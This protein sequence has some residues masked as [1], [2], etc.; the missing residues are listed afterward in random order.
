METEYEEVLNLDK[1]IQDKIVAEQ[2]RQAEIA[3]KAAEEKKKK[4]AAERNVSR[5][6]ADLQR[7]FLAVS[8]GNWTKPA[9]RKLYFWLWIQNA[10]NLR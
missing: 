2:K 10:S 9:I 3:R 5:L 4:A 7:R 8:A 1:A 6:L